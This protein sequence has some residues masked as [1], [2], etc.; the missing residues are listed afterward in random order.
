MSKSPF[1]II[2]IIRV[3]SHLKLMSETVK[4][5]SLS[6][7]NLSTTLTHQMNTVSTAKNEIEQIYFLHL[8]VDTSP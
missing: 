1:A 8:H 7:V 4:H 2:P 3:I 6:D 5:D